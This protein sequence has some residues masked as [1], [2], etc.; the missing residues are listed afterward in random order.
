MNTKNAKNTK[1]NNHI[2]DQLTPWPMQFLVLTNSKNLIISI[3]NNFQIFRYFLIYHEKQIVK[4]LLPVYH[5]HC[6]TSFN[7]RR[8]QQSE[9][10]YIYLYSVYNI[11]SALIWFLKTKLIFFFT[12][13]PRWWPRLTHPLPPHRSCFLLRSAIEINCYYLSP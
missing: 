11:H 2:P 6:I 10:I 8:H 1:I 5:V 13:D 12:W 9:N 3:S 4:F 7:L